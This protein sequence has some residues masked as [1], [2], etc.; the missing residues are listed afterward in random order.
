VSLPL[1]NVRDQLLRAGVAPRF[2]RRYVTE[3]RE[4]LADL[5]E[6]ERN[7]GLD[8]AAASDRAREL[9]GTDTQLAQAMIETTPRTLAARA[10][11]AVFTL[12]PFVTL[13]AFIVAIVAFM[14][15]LLEPVQPAWPG[16]VPNTHVG[17]IAAA[18][19]I[20]GYLLGP[21]IAAVCIFVSLRQRLSSLWVWVGVGL[22]AIT[23]SLFGFCVNVHP[24]F[25]GD[26]GGATFSVV[27]AVFVGGHF[28]VTATL[29]VA[30][31]RAAILITIA[32]FAYRCVRNRQCGAHGPVSGTAAPLEPA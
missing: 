31:L 32:A 9:L 8:A 24:P 5:T 1:E 4:H 15:R 18:S 20:T 12:L 13:L 21:A 14:F 2:A 17:V 10:P 28:S 7:A 3:L 30:A 27:R 19:F 25:G 16:G 26:P 6:R 29:S 23:S 11:W 22:V